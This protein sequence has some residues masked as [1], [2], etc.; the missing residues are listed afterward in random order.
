MKNKLIF[1]IFLLCLLLTSLNNQVSAINSVDV[2]WIHLTEMDF[3]S[4]QH[5]ASAWHGIDAPEATFEA[6]ISDKTLYIQ[7]DNV[8]SEFNINIVAADELVLDGTFINENNVIEIP[9]DEWSKGS[10]IIRIYYGEKM[11]IGEFQIEAYY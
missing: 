1:S 3:T 6:Y 5:S 10:Y 2:I 9:T 7:C 11:W 8:D 4:H